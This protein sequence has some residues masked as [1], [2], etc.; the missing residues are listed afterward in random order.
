MLLLEVPTRFGGKQMRTNKILHPPGVKKAGIIVVPPKPKP[1]PKPDK[2]TPKT[3]KS[4][5]RGKSLTKR[6]KPRWT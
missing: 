1:K 4:I 2:D 6:T 3:K 5:Y